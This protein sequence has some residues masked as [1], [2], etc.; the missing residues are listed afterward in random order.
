MSQTG[1][2]LFG[3]HVLTE[4]FQSALTISCLYK[5]YHIFCLINFL[6]TTIHNYDGAGCE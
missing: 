5:V 1:I 2:I 6:N 3:V 4:Q